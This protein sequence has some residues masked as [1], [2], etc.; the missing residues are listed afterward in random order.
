MYR[1]QPYVMGPV[2]W[3]EFGEPTVLTSEQFD[4]CIGS[5]VLEN[6]EKFNKAVFDPMLARRRTEAE[7]RMSIKQHLNVQVTRLE[8]NE[9]KVSPLH[10]EQG[11]YVGGK[12]D[13]IMLRPE[14]VSRKLASV[15]REAFSRAT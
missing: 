7:Q 8:T 3:T 10:R 4:S 5:A 11:G 9:V 2:S 12:E 6:L 1:V 14:E 13:S 15:I